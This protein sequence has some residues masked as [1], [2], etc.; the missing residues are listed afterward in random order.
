MTQITRSGASNLTSSE[1]RLCFPFWRLAAVPGDEQL[2]KLGNHVEIGGRTT[3]S[4]ESWMQHLGM[5]TRDLLSTRSALD[6]QA[7]TLP[8]GFFDCGADD[9][10]L[11]RAVVWFESI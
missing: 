3:T 11:L 7:F 8:R 4:F 9:C 5:D 6:R 10:H 1:L 2:S